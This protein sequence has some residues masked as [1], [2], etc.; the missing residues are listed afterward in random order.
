MAQ[1]AFL[2]WL[3]G[4]LESHGYEIQSKLAEHLGWQSSAINLLMSGNRTVTLEEADLILEFFDEHL[5]GCAEPNE[6]SPAQRLLDLKVRSGL[7]MRRMAEEMGYAQASSIQRYFSE[8]YIERQHPLHFVARLL[9]V[10]PGKGE[11]PI[12]YEEVISLVDTNSATV[13]NSITDIRSPD[14]TILKELRERTGLTQADLAGLANTSQ[15][16]I[17]RLETG[18]RTITADWAKRLAP[19]LNVDAADLLLEVSGLGRSSEL[20][21]VTANDD[22]SEEDSWNQRLIALRVNQRMSRAELA[23][24]AGVSYDSLNKYERGEVDQPRGKM[25]QKLAVVLGTTEQELRYGFDAETNTEAMPF[26]KNGTAIFPT[27]DGSVTVSYPE[28]LTPDSVRQLRQ[29]LEIFLQG[30]EE[31]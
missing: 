10:L 31:G 18:E 12:S 2:T 4:Q 8:D 21:H 7:S 13:L 19:H 9:K 22:T 26:N 24:R 23:R 17:R 5:F 11:P 28:N 27:K 20:D 29:Y 30:L 15:P 14:V 25:L 3:K 6:I 1:E 16:Q